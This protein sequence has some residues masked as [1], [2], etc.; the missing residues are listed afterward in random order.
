MAT[1]VDLCP[2]ETFTLKQSEPV[3]YVIKEGAFE[4]QFKRT[5]CDD[6]KIDN[7]IDSRVCNGIGANPTHTATKTH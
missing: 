4:V 7:M 3:F 1:V 6:D 2:N 5:G